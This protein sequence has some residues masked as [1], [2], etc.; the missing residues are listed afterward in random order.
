MALRRLTAASGS[1]FRCVHGRCL[2]RALA[3][4]SLSS[5]SSA[6]AWGMGPDSSSRS[7]VSR[8]TAVM[9]YRSWS[10]MAAKVRISP[11]TAKT[12]CNFLQPCFTFPDWR[13]AGQGGSD[14]CC[15]GLA[16]RSAALAAWPLSASR[17]SRAYVCARVRVR[18]RCSVSVWPVLR[19]G[20]GRL[21]VPP[22]GARG[23]DVLRPWG[24]VHGRRRCR[25]RRRQGVVTFAA[26]GV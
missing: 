4:R 5:L 11:E 12:F 26:V 16:A 10:S 18:V 15:R 13:H 20:P 19:A 7:P 3:V 8:L 14:V 9:M 24:R 17:P 2:C 23:R 6:A 1:A 21:W 25:R 22:M